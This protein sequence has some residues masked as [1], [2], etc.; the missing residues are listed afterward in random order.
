MVTTNLIEISDTAEYVFEFP[1]GW[2]LTFSSRLGSGPEADFEVLAH[3]IVCCM[4]READRTGR[5]IRYDA[6]ARRI[7]E[8]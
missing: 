8:A 6:A 1:K 7:V 3:V 2:I 5:K 4:G